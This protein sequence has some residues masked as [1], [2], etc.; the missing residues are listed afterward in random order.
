MNT[1][2]TMPLID[3]FRQLLLFDK[4]L[5]FIKSDDLIFSTEKIKHIEVAKW[6]PFLEGI[7][8]NLKNL[9]KEDG[10]LIFSRVESPASFLPGSYDFCFSIERI[11]NQDY[12]L[13]RIYDYTDMYDYLTQYQ[14][15]K[16]ERDIY[17]QKLEYRNGKLKNIEDLFS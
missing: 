3:K 12:I 1:K 4:N 16:N 9:K 5:R 15:L 8:D 6:L 17:R 10:E 13:W 2:T 14:Q 11:D 7:V